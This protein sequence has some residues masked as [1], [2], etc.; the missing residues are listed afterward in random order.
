MGPGIPTR[1]RPCRI[2]ARLLLCQTQSR[3][4]PSP[5]VRAVVV[6]IQCKVNRSLEVPAR[7]SQVVSGP[8]VDDDMDGMALG[9]Q[10]RDRIGELH[11]TACTL[12]DAA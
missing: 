12:V 10:Q 6:T 11:F 9:N 5:Q 2:V 4:Q 1:N 8:L 7:I 3:H